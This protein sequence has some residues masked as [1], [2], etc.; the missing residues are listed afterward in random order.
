MK[1]VWEVLGWVIFLGLLVNFGLQY[2]S[3]WECGRYMMPRTLMAA[4]GVHHPNGEPIE[5]VTLA[6]ARGGRG[7]GNVAC[8]P[9]RVGMGLAYVAWQCYLSVLREHSR[10]Q[11]Y[12]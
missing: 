10:N 12:H 7:R 3:R 6:I 9:V 8:G 2:G 1:W 4:D 5:S 11:S